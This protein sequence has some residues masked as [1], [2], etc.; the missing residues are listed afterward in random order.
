MQQVFLNLIKNALDAIPGG[1]S[2]DIAA[3]LRTE[4]EADTAFPADCDVKGDTIDISVRDSGTGMTAE[5]LARIFDPFFTTKDVGHGMGLGLFIVYQIIEE[6][7]GCITASS[8]EGKGTTFFIRLPLVVNQTEN[9]MQKQGK[10]LIVDDEAVALRN[11]ERV[12]S[13]VG[14]SVT[15]VQSGEEAL[16]LLETQAFDL[17]LTDLRMEK[18]DGMRLLKACRAR[19]PDSEVIMITGYASAQS[20]VEAMKQGAF[21]YITKPFRLDEVRK[22]VAEAMEKIRLRNENRSL[23][24]QVEALQGQVRIVTQDSG[25]LRLLELA[26]QVAPTDCNVLIVGESGTGKEL[27][28]RYLHQHSDRR[29]GPYV[30]VNC[31]AFSKD[32][33][34]NELFGHEKDAFTG[35]HS[36]KKGLIESATGGT[37]FLDEVTEMSPEMQVKLLRVI[38]EKEVLRLGATQPVKVD[39]RVIAATNRD[40]AEAVRSGM[41]RQDLYFRLNVVTL[42]IPP[43]VATQGRH[44]AAGAIFPAEVCRADEKVAE[45]HCARRDGSL[46]DLRLSRQR[47]RTGKHHRARL[48]RQLRR[49]HRTVASVRRLAPAETASPC[50][51]RAKNSRRWKSRKEPISRWVLNEFDGNQTAAA[52]ALGINRSSLWRK[53][54]TYQEEE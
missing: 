18:V 6:H 50:R 40:L 27:F 31:G 2:I 37:L 25:M 33:L 38:Q 30:A 54:K 43:L 3:R 4:N 48:C 22:V 45:R 23:K 46:A 10:L 52:A 53:L 47:A 8:A 29:A 21:Y 19:H 17:L 32:L 7:E 41:L 20:A 11:L 1:G 39:I 51:A 35:A 5:C 9:K 36:Q 42:A 15:A 24:Q 14:Y 34:A 12:M 44:S 13:K 28:A 26:R 16:A 49:Q